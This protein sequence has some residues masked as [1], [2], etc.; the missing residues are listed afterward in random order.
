M[1]DSHKTS[2]I[3][4]LR[5]LG[6]I[7]I[8]ENPDSLLLVYEESQ[9]KK[10]RDLIIEHLGLIKGVGLRPSKD[11]VLQTLFLEISERLFNID[12]D[13]LL[14]RITKR[15]NKEINVIE[16]E[17]ERKRIEKIYPLPTDVQPYNDN[18]QKLL[19][20]LRETNV[21]LYD[22]L[23]RQFRL[24]NVTFRYYHLGADFNPTIEEFNM[25]LDGLPPNIA[26]GH[27]E[28]GF[29]KAKN[30]LPF[31]RFYM[32]IHDVGLDEYLK[33]YLSDEDFEYH[34]KSS[35]PSI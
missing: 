30:S 13:E 5:E 17:M 12:E 25:W 34:I 26:D 32:E 15:V 3:T 24:G 31:R 27:R 20:S 10:V 9:Q 23:S 7:T 21:S 8:T 16:E 11:E 22:M 29:E 28:M 19:D 4:S 1:G 35:L 33:K 2:L 6:G 18:Q 14:S